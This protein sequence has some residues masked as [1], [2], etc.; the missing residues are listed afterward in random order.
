M[1]AKIPND[2]FKVWT[3]EMAYVLG[4]WWADGNM[5]QTAAGKRVSFTSKD[6]EHLEQ[7]VRVIGVGR[8]TTKGGKYYELAIKRADMYDDLLQ[9]G[10]T[11]GKSLTAT[12]LAPPSEFLRHF[13]RGF[14]D[15]DGS[16]YWLLT[17]ITTHPRIQVVGTEQ[18]LRGMALAIE[19]QTGSP[20]PT[21]FPS[22]NIWRM[23]WSGM[24]AKCLASWLYEG[25]DVCLERKR[26]IAL[27]FFRWQPK[28]YRRKHITPKMGALF[29]QLLPE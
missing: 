15:G 22:E 1:V 7:I 23:T 29:G 4:Y 3:P 26:S 24:Y 14:V 27:E 8:V 11:P 12:W 19:N 2:F 13:V 9:L 21:C 20:V 28:L 18:F 16:L 5:L 25:C 6:G 17:K 10:G